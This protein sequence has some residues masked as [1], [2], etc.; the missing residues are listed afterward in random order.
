[1]AAGQPRSASTILGAMLDSRNLRSMAD[2]CR[3]LASTRQT[4]EATRALL[5]MADSYDLQAIQREKVQSRR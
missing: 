1:M 5:R 3:T 4:A 2:H